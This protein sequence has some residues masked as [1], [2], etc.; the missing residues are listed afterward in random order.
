MSSR[1][2]CLSVTAGSEETVTV[3]MFETG[4]NATAKCACERLASRLALPLALSLHTPSSC[5]HRSGH[6]FKA[7]VVRE[8]AA[9]A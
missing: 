3:L 8:P 5:S 6:N 1:F 4:I 9:T 7:G 2:V